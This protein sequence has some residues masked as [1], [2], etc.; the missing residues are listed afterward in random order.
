[1]NL[2]EWIFKVE[3][4]KYGMRE[5]MKNKIMKLKDHLIIE[6]QERLLCDHEDILDLRRGK[7][8]RYEALA[9]YAECAELLIQ[10]EDMGTDELKKLYIGD[11][12]ELMNILNSSKHIV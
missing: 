10:I 8:F 9:S 11:S 4:E 7:S 1:M 12:Y 3:L 6:L 5:E 2:L